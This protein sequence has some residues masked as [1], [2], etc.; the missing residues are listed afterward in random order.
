MQNL[1]DALFLQIDESKLNHPDFRAS[2]EGGY[3]CYGTACGLARLFSFFAS[4][5]YHDAYMGTP[6]PSY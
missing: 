6:Y 3:N 1:D 2:P 5:K 4:A